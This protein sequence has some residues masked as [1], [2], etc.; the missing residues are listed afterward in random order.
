MENSGVLLIRDYR[1]GDELSCSEVVHEGTMSTVNRAFFSALIR[2]VTFQ[3]MVLA[4][5]VMFIFMGLP[6]QV[7][8]ANIVGATKNLKHPQFY[9]HVFTSYQGW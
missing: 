1:P 3:L 2:E 9:R 4:S 8:D 5:A 6:L 7:S